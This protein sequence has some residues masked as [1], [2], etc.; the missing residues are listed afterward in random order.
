MM[1]TVKIEPTNVDSASNDE[2]EQDAPGSQDDAASTNSADLC[3]ND[4]KLVWDTDKLEKTYDNDGKKVWHCRFCGTSRSGWNHTKAKGRVL[5]GR[6][7]KICNNI[8]SK[9]A[10]IFRNYNMLEVYTIHQG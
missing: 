4:F 9:W 7:V 3:S 10:V 2:E 1:E 5:G 8:L 6:D